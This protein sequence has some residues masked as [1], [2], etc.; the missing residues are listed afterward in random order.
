MNDLE[1]YE[2]IFERI[3]NRKPKWTFEEISKTL[4]W[5]NKRTGEPLTDRKSAQ[6]RY[7]RLC[8]S[9][10]KQ[11][12]PAQK[13]KKKEASTKVDRES[14]PLDKDKKKEYDLLNM[15]DIEIQAIPYGEIEPTLY[16]SDM[17]NDDW[18]DQFMVYNY[19]MDINPDLEIKDDELEQDDYGN[20]FIPYSVDDFTYQ[21]IDPEIVK[22]HKKKWR[23]KYLS[24]LSDALWN[25]SRAMGLL[26]RG[27]GKTERV[28]ALFIRWILEVFLPLMV[29]TPKATHSAK[30][31]SKIERAIKHP[32]IRRYYG[33]VISGT[34]YS[35]DGMILKYSDKIAW[36]HLDYPLELYTFKSAKEGAHPAWLH[37]EDVFQ[38]EAKSIDV[39]ISLIT[40]FENKFIPMLSAT[41]KFTLTAT[42]YGVT[43]FYNYLI[44]IQKIPVLHIRAMDDDNVEWLACPRFTKHYLT[45]WKDKNPD[46]FETQMNNN[47]IPPQ[48]LYFQLSDWKPITL[49]PSPVTVSGYYGFLDPAEG[50]SDSADNSA[51]R[52]VA[53]VDGKSLTVDG[54]VGKFKQ[55]ELLDWM[56]FF[57]KK[58]KMYEFHVEKLFGLG[59]TLSHKLNHFNNIRYYT[60]T[61]P[62]A[63]HMRIK[64]L[65]GF[66]R[67]GLIRIVKTIE[68]YEGGLKMG[69]YKQSRLEYLSYEA[70]KDSSASRKDDCLDTEGMALDILAP[71]LY[72]E[73]KKIVDIEPMR[74]IG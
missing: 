43:D 37:F 47:P 68:A 72:V 4:K 6:K 34:S 70:D 61:Q 33:D 9:L 2:F 30:I 64:A 39:T 56:E 28:I 3:H 24:Q 44:K 40:E 66:Y 36:H 69:F 58:Y 41:S 13:I 21:S 20:F 12:K 42:R 16:K 60:R 29:I 14:K 32:S 11:Y 26:P 35:K 31:L 22:A 25:Y 65:R 38:Q 73:K 57:Q 51:I 15:T 54:I 50:L 18:I 27:Y 71:Y 67:R 48:G 23:L 45:E 5:T 62:K 59:V 55:D 7:R 63:K 1:E 46:S 53:I 49:I 19:T 8:N 17:N 74:I 52:I 10:N